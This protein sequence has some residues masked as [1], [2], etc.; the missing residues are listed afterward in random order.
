M[1]GGLGYFLA[2]LRERTQRLENRLFP[3]RTHAPFV[4][5]QGTKH[6]E[7]NLPLHRP[8]KVS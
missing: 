5:D 4:R 1:W 2:R 3:A 7:A 8:L 6:A